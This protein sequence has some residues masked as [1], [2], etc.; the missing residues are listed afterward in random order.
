MYRTPSLPGVKECLV[1]QAV[2]KDHAE[3]VLLYEDNKDPQPA[4]AETAKAE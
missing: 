4:P 3:P 2:V 1:N